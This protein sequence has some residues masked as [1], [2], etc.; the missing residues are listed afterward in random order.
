MTATQTK[1]EIP[2]AWNYSRP[3]KEQL[4]EIIRLHGAYLRGEAEGVRA[5]LRYADLRY[6]DLSYADLSDADL[7]YAD[8]SY[9][10]LSYADLSDADLRYADLSYANLSDANL[11]Y[12]DL[13]YANLSDADLRY[14]DLRYADLRY[15]DLRYADLSYANLRYA[16]LSDANLRYADLRYADLS[17][18]NLRYAN[19][20]DDTVLTDGVVWK[21]YVEELVPALLTAG[22][23]KLE[24]IANPEN[25]ACHTWGAP[26]QLS[27]PIATAFD[28]HNTADVPALYRAQSNLFIQLFDQGVIPL[29]RVLGKKAES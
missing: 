8:L 5:D 25:W 24:E 17:Y 18:A 1:I 29:D 13:R 27:C 14:A 15:A 3:T 26:G 2:T 11:R 10:D 7:R 6:A 21:A 12:A 23:K 9:A 22:G 28:V 4:A 19:L 20:S 16:N